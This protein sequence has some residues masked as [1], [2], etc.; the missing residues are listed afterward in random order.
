MTDRAPDLRRRFPGVRAGV[1][2]F[3]GPAGTLMVDTA[4]E[5]TRD[6]LA[7]GDSANLGGPFV[8]SVRTGELVD[9][10]RT[11]VATLLGADP[12]GVV[13]GANMTTLTFAFTRA[14]ARDLG[15]GD[16]IVCT[17]LDHDANVTPWVMAAKDRGAT[18][19]FAGV[20]AATGRLPTEAVTDKLSTR[21]RW[22]AVTGA[23]NLLGTIPDVT[24]ITTAAH[25]A[26][27]RV[28]VDAVHLT[29]HRRVDV[30]VIGCDVLATSPY[31]WY[32]PHAGILAIDPQ[33]LA[34]LTPY[35]VRPAG[36]DGP[37][38]LETGTPSFE[39]IAGID[40]AAQFLLDTGMDA[41][42]AAESAIFTTLLDGLQA[43]PRVRIHGPADGT[44]RT[45][46]VLFSLDGISSTDVAGHLAQQSVAVWAGHSYAVEVAEAMH[47]D[48]VRAGVVAYVN[49]EDVF[50]LLTALTA[51]S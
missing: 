20:D 30:S 7:S 41:I 26:G 32:G 44:D 33:L 1:A 39:A 37:R 15:P 25:D 28:F 11:T 42:G 46:T 27:A 43:L 12:A 50:Q 16:E 18:I 8:A 6:H 51:L 45:P 2:R 49:E 13:F 3:D 29:P 21:T 22:V 36:D 47:L 48:G 34:T 9:R 4:I 10:A 5:A 38:R 40:A 19:V 23:S 17:T 31:K 35:K 24:A 14:I